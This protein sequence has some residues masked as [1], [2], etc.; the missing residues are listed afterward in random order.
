ME[1]KTRFVVKG[2]EAGGDNSAWVL[3]IDGAA[4]GHICAY[5]DEEV[6]REINA[7]LDKRADTG[8]VVI[9]HREGRAVECVTF[10]STLREMLAAETPFFTHYAEVDAWIGEF[11]S[12]ARYLRE[13]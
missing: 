12:M 8:D 10:H 11:E 4:P 5:I 9:P 2:R 1:K 3:S 13:F 7:Q 6:F